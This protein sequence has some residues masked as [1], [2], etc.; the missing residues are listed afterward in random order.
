MGTSL[1]TSLATKGEKPL[2]AIPRAAGCFS[3]E[4]ECLRDA[5]VKTSNGITFSCFA[6]KNPQQDG[7]EN[8]KETKG[9]IS[10]TINNLPR[11]SPFFV[12]FLPFLH[13]NA[14][15]RVLWKP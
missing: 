6:G 5:Y 10:K 12:H 15:F 3:I 4:D 7:N 1:A 11:A 8:V 14:K 13:E 2:R 9:L